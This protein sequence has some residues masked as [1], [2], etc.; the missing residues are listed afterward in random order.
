M[1]ERASWVLVTLVLCFVVE[2]IIILVLTIIAAV[3][4]TYIG[5][6]LPPPADITVCTAT[7]SLPYYSAYFAP[8]FA[9]EFLLFGLAVGIFCRHV[10][11]IRRPQLNRTSLVAVLVWDNL[12]YYAIG[13]LLYTV[14]LIIWL[15]GNS[16]WSLAPA[17]FS[18][19]ITAIVG[20][21]LIL[22]LCDVFY[23]PFGSQTSLWAPPPLELARFS[24]TNES[25][26]IPMTR[27]DACDQ[28]ES[29]GRFTETLSVG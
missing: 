4:L 2:V 17:V 5:L 29:T 14:N 10:A 6:V 28:I 18:L 8:I 7:T 24:L 19:S 25:M 12:I 15:S 9:F 26:G 3:R 20:C 13:V 11:D 1:Y 27:R 23:R 21:R 16:T 22:H